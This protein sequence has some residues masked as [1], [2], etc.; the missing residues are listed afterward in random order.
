[1]K[2]VLPEGLNC[3]QMAHKNLKIGFDNGYQRRFANMHEANYR[4]DYKKKKKKE[5]KNKNNNKERST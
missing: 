3:V 2:L 4:R 1:M 5:K